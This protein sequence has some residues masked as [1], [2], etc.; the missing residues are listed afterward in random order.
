MPGRKWN[1]FVLKHLRICFSCKHEF[2]VCYQLII[3]LTFGS[4][5]NDFHN[6]NKDTN[7]SAKCS[8]PLQGKKDT[9]NLHG[10]DH[11]LNDD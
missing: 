11:A 2:T 5:W 1:V 10:A 8:G 9:E 7:V 6:N 4:L 3:A